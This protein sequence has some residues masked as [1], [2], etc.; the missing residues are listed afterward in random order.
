MLYP[1]EDVQHL[2]FCCPLYDD[3]RNNLL[4]S[5]QGVITGEVTTEL[6]LFGSEELSKNENFI[7]IDAVQLFLKDTKRFS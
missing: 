5:V 1:R 4:N 2:L 3:I 7:I 6:L